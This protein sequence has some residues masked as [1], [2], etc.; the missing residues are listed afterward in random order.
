[1]AKVKKTKMKKRLTISEEFEIMK[2]VL[3]K[4]LWLGFIIMGIGFY[5]VAVYGLDRFIQGFGFMISGILILG[6]AVLILIKEF[7][8]IS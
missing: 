6:L 5:N 2:L 7:E 3:D 4:F 8:I 1:M